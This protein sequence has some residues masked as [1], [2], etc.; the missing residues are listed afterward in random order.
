MDYKNTINLKNT[1]HIT[2]NV[3]HLTFKNFRLIHCFFLANK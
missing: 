2:L 3:L 1:L